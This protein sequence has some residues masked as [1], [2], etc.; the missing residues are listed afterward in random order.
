LIIHRFASVKF[1]Y[2]SLEST[3]AHT[4]FIDLWKWV[5]DFAGLSFHTTEKTLSDAFSNYG[6]VVEGSFKLINKMH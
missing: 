3:L 4:K 5:I 6:Q 1:S 2:T